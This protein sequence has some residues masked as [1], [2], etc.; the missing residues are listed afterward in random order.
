MSSTSEPA[1]NL[2]S[3]LS[4]ETWRDCL[5]RTERE[6]WEAL[7]M[8]TD[9]NI[10]EMARIAQLNRTHVYHRLQRCGLHERQRRNEHWRQYGLNDD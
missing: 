9:R 10:S 1:T 3:R 5:L 2:P 6:Y 8:A 7:M 4:I